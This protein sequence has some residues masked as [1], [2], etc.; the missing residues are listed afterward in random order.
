MTGSFGTDLDDFTDYIL[1]LF[2]G[3]GNS[4]I[5]LFSDSEDS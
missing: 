3:L 2:F 5:L 4:D 1:F